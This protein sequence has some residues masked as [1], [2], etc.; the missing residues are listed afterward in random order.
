MAA[1]S[2]PRDRINYISL[3]EDPVISTPSRRVHSLSNFD[4]TFSLHQRN[5]RIKLSLEPN[6]D[7][8]GHEP[9]MHFVDNEG[10][11]QKIVSI[12]PHDHKVYKGWAFI[13]SENGWERSGWARIVVRQDGLFPLFEGTFTIMHDHHHVMLRSDYVQTRQELDPTL[14]DS[15]DEYMIV[16]RDSDVGRDIHDNLKRSSPIERACGT[17]RL[18]FNTNPDHPIF[19][20][21][22]KPDQSTWG[23]MSLDYML[24]LGKRQSDISGG[25]GGGPVNVRQTIGSTA[26]CPQTRKVA[27]IGVAADC[28]YTKSFNSSVQAAQRNIVSV[29]NS[30]SQL[31]EQTFNITLGLKKVQVL[32]GDCPSTAPPSTPWNVGCGTT[33]NPGPKIDE[34][35]TMFSAWRGE[36]DD[37]NA[38]WML[39]TTCNSGSEVGLAWLGQVCINTATEQTD[40]ETNVTQSVS[41][42]G[43]V[44]RTPQEWQVFAHEAGHIFGAVHDCDSDLCARPR[45]VAGSRCCPRSS[46]ICDANGQFIMN[47][48]SGRGITAFSQCTLGQVCTAMGRGGVRTNCFTNN[49][50]VVT[51]AGS[52]CG[53]GIVEEGEDCDCGGEQFCE[54]NPCCDAQTCKFRNNAVCDDSNEECCSNCQFSSANTVCRASTGPCDPEERCTGR[55]GI[56]PED[57]HKK[58]GENCGNGLACAS[59]QCTSRDMQCKVLM[60]NDTSA[61]DSSSC[62]MR[63]SSPS[64]PP[65]VCPEGMQFFLDGTPCIAGGVCRNVSYSRFLLLSLTNS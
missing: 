39:M 10:N 40:P 62:V 56:C 13:E 34:R 41:S 29:V 52:E 33:Q 37:T 57:A 14:E 7:I 49:R 1:H 54:D 46:D 15:P 36:Q 44:V 47:P 27:L 24:G 19:R 6:H 48:T 64:L 8:L 4:V 32:P 35:L 43:V 55:S 17:D 5:Q 3:V 20:E 53:N 23:S 25:N 21:P 50:N 18:E 22:A 61:C 31:Y 2:Q 59:G 58:N 30:A 65:D 26:G 11:T 16:F 63:C 28:E 51:Y 38:F 60:D 9:E 45:L 12:D 42:T